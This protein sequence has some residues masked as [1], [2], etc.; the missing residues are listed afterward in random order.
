M[1]GLFLSFQK[2]KVHIKKSN[3]ELLGSELE[4]EGNSMNDPGFYNTQ[5]LKLYLDILNT[6]LYL[7]SDIK[8]CKN[9]QIITL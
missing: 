5:Q 2:S 9:T 8:S 4:A 7:E 6:N 1:Y 3:V